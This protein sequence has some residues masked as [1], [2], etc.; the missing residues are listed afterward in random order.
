ME[1]TCHGVHVHHSLVVVL[2]E[3]DAEVLDL[4]GLLL[5]DGLDGDDLSG[6]LLELPELA[7]EV[8]EA[9]LGHDAVQSTTALGAKV[10]ME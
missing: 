5:V 1:L 8:P 6:G 9:G 10:R 3:P 4:Q 7:E 2:P